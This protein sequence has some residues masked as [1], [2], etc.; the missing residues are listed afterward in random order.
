MT[1]AER[2]LDL[3]IGELQRENARLK[4]QLSAAM[5][6]TLHL[7]HTMQHIYAQALLALEPRI[8]EHDDKASY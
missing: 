6:E 2:E 4:R 1:E 5:E 3:E 8:K 7:R